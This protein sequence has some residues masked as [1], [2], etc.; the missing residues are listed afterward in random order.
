MIN[1][2]GQPLDCEKEPCMMSCVLAVMTSTCTPQ[3]AMISLDARV[4][5]GN[6]YC[7]KMYASGV[8]GESGTHH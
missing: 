7:G 8:V 6:C 3:S 4:R 5:N 1:G 2:R